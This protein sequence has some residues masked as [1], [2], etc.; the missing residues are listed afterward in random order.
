VSLIAAPSDR[1]FRRAHVKP[2][3][4]RGSWRGLLRRVVTYGAIALVT[5]F[6]A[7]R[8]GAVVA[9]ARVLRIDRIDVHG[10]ERLSSGEV[11]AVLTGLR[12]EH[13]VWTDL[14]AWRRR[15]LAS[16]W[17]RD[18]S[19][20][21]SLPST[22]DVTVWERAPI[23]IGRIDHDLYLFDEHATLIDEYGP[24]YADLDL[25]IV[26]GLALTGGP[27]AA[28]DEA[29]AELA[30][31]VITA[32]RFQPAVAKRVSQLDVADLHNV[33]VI[34][35][36]DPAVI[37]VGDDRFLERLQSYLDL[38]EVLRARV[39]EIDYVD[40]RF[41]GRIFVRPVEKPQVVSR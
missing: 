22:V 30:G 14:A 26:D 1:R 40:L 35:N 19:L 39:P 33:A 4:R 29:R 6:G 34:L 5:A 37:Y 11:M 41:D 12:G 27:G 20:R 36:G 17:V 9:Q 23:A 28:A 8:G 16:P 7:Y 13:I 21:R 38:S 31:R 10:N 2:A 3:R 18:A 15:L 24:Q 25:P 32:L